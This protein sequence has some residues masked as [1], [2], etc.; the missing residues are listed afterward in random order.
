MSVSEVERVSV[1]D[2]AGV[3][4]RRF[5]EDTELPKLTAGVLLGLDRTA[6]HRLHVRYRELLEAVRR[7]LGFA[8]GGLDKDGSDAAGWRAVSWVELSGASVMVLLWWDLLS[9]SSP[10]DVFPVVVRRVA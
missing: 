1:A 3:V 6:P 10:E 2:V 9:L 8:A 5:V 7:D 4:R